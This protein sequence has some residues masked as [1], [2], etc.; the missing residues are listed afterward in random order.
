MR[1]VLCHVACWL[2]AGGVHAML[3]LWVDTVVELVGYL[4]QTLPG[5]HVAYGLYQVAGSQL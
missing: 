4:G 5:R 3:E 1:A 2:T